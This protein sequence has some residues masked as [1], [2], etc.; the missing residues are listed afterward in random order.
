MFLTNLDSSDLLA[1]YTQ[2]LHDSLTN[3]PPAV[4]APDSG[5]GA[6]NQADPWQSVSIFFFSSLL[7]FRVD[8]DVSPSSAFVL[9][10][11]WIY[12][13]RGDARVLSDNYAGM[14]QYIEFELGRSPNN[15]A[16]TG[17]GDW[18]TPVRI[19]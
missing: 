9:I 2:D 5:W 4:I 19:F 14:K 3:G 7:N 8:V 1:K 10:P 12:T 17:L 11:A 18:D 16:S 6:N 15:I 13:Y